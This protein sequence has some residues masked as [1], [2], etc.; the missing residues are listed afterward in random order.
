M[1]PSTIAVVQDFINR[2]TESHVP[3]MDPSARGQIANY[4]ST[5]AQLGLK[6]SNSEEE[7]REIDSI[8]RSAKD[9]QGKPMI[10]IAQNYWDDPNFAEKQRR[11]IAQKKQIN[12]GNR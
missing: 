1:Y 4:D 9:F 10:E 3:S 12:K 8:F 6:V 7:F 5:V 2:Q 11:E